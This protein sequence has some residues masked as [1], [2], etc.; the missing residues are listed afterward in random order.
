[1][2]KFVVRLAI[3]ALI[4]ALGDLLVGLVSGKLVAHA[5]GGNTA[6]MCYIAKDVN[7]DILIFGSSRAI[8]HYDPDVLEDT[9]GMSVYNCGFDGNGIICAYGYYK[10]VCERYCPDVLIYDISGY[11][12]MT[13]DNHRYLGNLRY[14]FDNGDVQAIFRDVDMLEQYK[15]LS[16]MYRYNSMLPQIVMDNFH[17]LHPNSKG[18]QPLNGEMKYIPK[19]TPK[20]ESFEYDSLKLDYLERLI[21]ECQGKTRLVFTLSPGFGRTDEREYEP[22]K[23]L[24]AR[25]DIPLLS[26]FTDT[27]FNIHKEYFADTGH[28]NHRGAT[29]YTK[30]FAHEVKEL[31]LNDCAEKQ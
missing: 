6:R 19:F 16:G 10:M 27:T 15:M 14:F 12:L 25:Y 20:Q 24:C 18:F 23:E 13:D 2:K 7:A 30:T 28:L 11:D 5:K 29:A 9:L 26:H 17:P 22:L 3:F 4:M 1:M 31:L 8:H 21:N